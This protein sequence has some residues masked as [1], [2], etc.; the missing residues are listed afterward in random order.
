[1]SFESVLLLDT[2]YRAWVG[3]MDDKEERLGKLLFLFFSLFL[4][5]FL[6]FFFIFIF[7]IFLIYI[8][9]S[10]SHGESLGGLSSQRVP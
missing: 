10:R 2:C 7:F 3:S 1:M 6:Y 8:S 9:L 4:S 5:F